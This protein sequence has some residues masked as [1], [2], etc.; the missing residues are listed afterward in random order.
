LG[1]NLK[2]NT[3]KQVEGMKRDMA[4]KTIVAELKGKRWIPDVLKTG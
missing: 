3:R 2:P 1:E 4:A